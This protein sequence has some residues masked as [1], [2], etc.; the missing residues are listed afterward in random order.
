[1]YIEV[2]EMAAPKMHYGE[3]E[4]PEGVEVSLEGRF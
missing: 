1:M 3:I 2:D 4:V